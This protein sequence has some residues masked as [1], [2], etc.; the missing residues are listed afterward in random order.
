MKI[1]ILQCDSTRIQF[2]DE[3]GDYPE[4]FMSL[5]KSVDPGMGFQKY[6]VQ[7]EQYP[8]TPEECEVY[9]ITGSRYSVYDE[10]PWIKKLEKYVVELHERKFPMLGICFG[11][12]MIAQ[13]LGG[14]T[15]PAIQGWGVGVQNYQT[16]SFHTWTK[17]ALEQFSL[18][19]SHM[20]QVT[21]LP[22]GAELIA[23][24]DF[25]PHAAFIIEDHILTFQAHPE[26]QKSYSKA[27]LNHRKKILGPKVFEAG[28]KSLEGKIQ[29]N[30]I[31]HWMLKFLR[32]STLPK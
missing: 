23:E 14:K 10:A 15:E 20:D 21:K 22:A 17:P 25:C 30:Q 18:L 5:F 4:M 8:Q 11:H 19:A 3:H 2:R 27:L 29:P 32:K 7:L 31:T 16:V 13:A 1:G 6:D 9:L 24:S 26:F 28:I 12:Q